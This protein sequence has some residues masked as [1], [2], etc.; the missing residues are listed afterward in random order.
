MPLPPPLSPPPGSRAPRRGCASRAELGG[1]VGSS[2][3]QAARV[4]KGRV[5]VTHPA[6]AAKAP[7]L[8]GGE[9]GFRA[10][11]LA[12]LPELVFVIAQHMCPFA[13]L[14]QLEEEEE[15][16]GGRLSVEGLKKRTWNKCSDRN[17]V[18]L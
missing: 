1:R 9:R 2:G 12:L 10:I 15:E 3:E 5:K 7:A 17:A 6:Q 11:L 16:K 18:H 4:L 14:L 8:D 13:L